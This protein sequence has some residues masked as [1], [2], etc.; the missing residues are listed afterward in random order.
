VFLFSRMPLVM[1]AHHAQY[2]L[3]LPNHL[4]ISPTNRRAP[5]ARHLVRA[6]HKSK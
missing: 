5:I 3:T 6:T 2:T 1:T 4:Y